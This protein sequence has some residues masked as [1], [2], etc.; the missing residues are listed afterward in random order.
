VSSPRRSPAKVAGAAGQSPSQVAGAAG[1]RPPRVAVV[2]E[3]YPSQRDPVLGIWAHRQALAARDAGADVRVLVLHR[4]VP[5]RASLAAGPRAAAAA[6]AK[7]LREPR[8][9]T[10]DGLPVSYVP[11]VSPP[12]DRSYASWGAWAA[13]ALAIALRRLDRA[14]PFDLVHAHN[15]VPAGDATRR[16]GLARPIIISIHGGD[17]L[18]TAVRNDAGARAVARSLH[19]ASLV[20]ANSH[21][22]A[23]LARAHGARQTRVVHL[24]TDLPIAPR[25]PRHDTYAASEGRTHA[26]TWASGGGRPT[27]AAQS[28][29]TV[30]HLIAR[31]RHADVLRAL[32]V[33]A[34]AAAL[35]FSRSPGARRWGHAGLQ[36]AENRDRLFLWARAAEVADAQDEANDAR[37]AAH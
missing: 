17:V 14:F 27:V 25:L 21:G 18:Y 22:I 11:Y 29:V 16:A 30:G 32:A 4:L 34:L 6:A 1:Q 23:E 37:Q 20:L 12:R 28:L 9:Q 2:A 35:L 19:A 5:S 26:D 8:A 24:G 36:P 31:K 33:L 7:L 10:R 13:P 3:F 15:A